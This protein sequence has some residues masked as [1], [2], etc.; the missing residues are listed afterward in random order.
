M[1]NFSSFL[2]LAVNLIGVAVMITVH[3]TTTFI[4]IELLSLFLFLFFLLRT[5]L[6]LTNIIGGLVWEFH[7][8]HRKTDT[9]G[10]E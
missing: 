7:G 5:L 8:K 1:I 3:T 4:E 6:D 2:Y 9:G 10:K